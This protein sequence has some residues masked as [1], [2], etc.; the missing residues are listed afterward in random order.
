MDWSEGAEEGKAG[1]P[2]SLCA[3]SPSPALPQSGQVRRWG[4]GPSSG[5]TCRISPHLLYSSFMSVWSCVLPED[6]SGTRCPSLTP[7]WETFARVVQIQPFLDWWAEAMF[8][9]SIQ[10]YLLLSGQLDPFRTE[11]SCSNS[12]RYLQSHSL[13]LQLQ[14]LLLLLCHAPQVSP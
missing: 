10:E 2:W 8:G 9:R 5:T 6:I 14:L 13:Q 4:D 11:F 7:V 12:H 1:T 3:I